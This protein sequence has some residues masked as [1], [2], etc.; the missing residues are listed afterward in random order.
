MVFVYR[1]DMSLLSWIAFVVICILSFMISIYVFLYDPE[2]KDKTI[3]LQYRVLKKLKRLELSRKAQHTEDNNSRVRYIERIRL[4][5]M[6][7][8]FDDLYN[9]FGILRYHDCVVCKEEG[10]VF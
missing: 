2:A 3:K 4:S 5:Q 9:F 10:D 1:Q 7:L 8:L 6:P